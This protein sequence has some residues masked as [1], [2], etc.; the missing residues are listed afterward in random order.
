YVD[1]EVEDTALCAIDFP[2]LTAEIR[3]TWAANER[4]TR[5]QLVGNDGRMTVDDD[6]LVM[7]G[8]GAETS[9]QLATALSAGSH[10]PDWFTGVIDEFRCELD[11]PQ[12]RGANQAEAELCLLMLD[13][14]YASGAQR[15]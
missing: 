11:D 9:R 2:S 3:L 5:W 6:R 4:R 8:R 15:S 14:A 10:H 12:T 7:H 1:A 13:L